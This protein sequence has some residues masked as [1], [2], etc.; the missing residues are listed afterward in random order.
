MTPPSLSELTRVF[1]RIGLLSF[2]GP[3]AQ[4]ALMQE[5]LV[6]DRA[7]LTRPQFLN[8]LS[9]CM[10]LPGPEAMQ[11]AT[12]AGWKLRGTP[13]GLIAGGLFVVPGAC[14][15]F[16][17]AYAYA[18]FGDLP[19]VDGVFLGIQAAVIVLVF[20]ALLGLARKTLTS[21]DRW[22]LAALSFTALFV[23]GVPFPAIIAAAALYGALSARGPVT[24]SA[25]SEALP[26]PAIGTILTWLTAWLAP[27]AVLWASGADL[28][29]QIALFFAKLAVVTFGGAY[30]VLAYMT[31]EVVQERGWL[32]P[33]QMIDALGLA[34][35]TPGPLILVTQFVGFLAGF[36]EGGLGLAL[37]AGLITL[38]VTFVP[39]FLWIFTFA[40]YVEWIATRPR[41]TGALQGITAAVV[42]VILNLVLWFA[43]HVLFDSLRP[44]AVPGVVAELPLL[45]SWNGAALGLTLFAAY[46]M[47]RL[48]LEF[49]VVLAFC[50]TAA[51]VI[52]LI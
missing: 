10:L 51:G 34:E 11:L 47:L 39:C 31:Q 17:L 12:Y 29:S 26:H 28:L 8:A 48:K 46:L 15:I 6:E 5:E 21:R 19:L 4:I 2:G 42:G 40:P 38:W 1:G 44:V 43:L 25:E 9:F 33:E 3:A 37:I 50:A 22:M 35:T 7:W 30:A 49:P 24:T 36:A 27:I 16:A 45:A 13:G 23:F 52:T 41:L 18:A 32:T 14:V 20:K